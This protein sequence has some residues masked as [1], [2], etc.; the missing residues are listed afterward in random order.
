MNNS[1]SLEGKTALITGGG[2]GLGYGIAQSFIQNGAKIVIIGRRENI[3]KDAAASLG[4]NCQYLA[5]DLHDIARIP[6]LIDRI[7]RSFGSIDILVNNAGNHIK[8]MAE[9]MSDEEFISIINLHVLSV[10]ALTRETIKRMKTRKGGS[11]LFLSSMTALMGQGKVVAYSTAKT[12]ILGMMRNLVV[13]YAQ[14]NIRFNA[15]APGWI[16]SP[17]LHKAIDNDPPRKNRIL[18]RIP[19]G[20]FGEAA[21]IGNAAVYLSSDA[22]K[23]VSGVLLPVDYGASISF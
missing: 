1:F 19:S 13:E 8:K 14:D 7:E 3:L 9:E 5:A 22:A 23:Y 18:Q 21:D 17:M 12:G 10:F 6:E 15:I 16:E 4:D 20:K 2:T 11:V